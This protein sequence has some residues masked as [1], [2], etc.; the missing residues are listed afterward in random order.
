MTAPWTAGESRAADATY[1]RDTQASKTRIGLNGGK[2][3]S[4]YMP[5]KQLSVRYRAGIAP[6]ATFDYASVKPRWISTQEEDTPHYGLNICFQRADQSLFAGDATN[7]QSCRI[8]YTYYI[9]CK[10]V[11]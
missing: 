5:T 10:G 1:M 7:Y 3:I 4:F 8:E 9:A 6:V 11:H 2:P